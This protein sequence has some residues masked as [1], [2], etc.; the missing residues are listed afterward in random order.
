M[1]TV[2]PV[3]PVNALVLYYG[4]SLSA[5][6]FCSVSFVAIK[7]TKKT[8]YSTQLLSMGLLVYDC[9]FLLSASVAK[10]FTYEE[11]YFIQHFSRGCQIAAQIIVGSMAIE[12]LLVL[13]WP[14]VYLRVATNRLTKTV[15]I[16]IFILSF[17]Q[18]FAVRGI[19]CFAI[20]KPIYCG[21][22]MS[23]YFISMC[24]ISIVIE[25][26]SYVKVFR[27]VRRQQGS[28][29]Q[30]KISLQQYK[31]TL[32]TFVYLVNSSISLSL[33]LGMA[34]VFAARAARKANANGIMAVIADSVYVINC[35]IDPLVYV[36]WFKETRLEVLKM[37]LH[38]F[39]CVRGRLCGFV[40]KRK[41]EKMRM[42]I[43]NITVTKCTS[44]QQTRILPV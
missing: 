16:I 24:V 42:E 20:N 26:V 31:G 36:M 41:I 44:N 18:F 17:L 29:R 6:V 39:P 35:I 10:L 13:Q 28:H 7:R 25:V 14:Y 12:R 43:F 19:V 27:I 33:Y 21:S 1:V 22:I 3:L 4:M 37:V 2:T 34:V 38:V 32:A 15:C 9:L 23:Y 40:V 5:F 8:P 30:H 11:S